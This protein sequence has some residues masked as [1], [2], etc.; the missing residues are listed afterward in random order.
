MRKIAVEKGRPSTSKVITGRSP[1]T[2]SAGS[3][4]SDH[5]GTHQWNFTG[6]TPEWTDSGEP[7]QKVTGNLPVIT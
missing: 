1:V 5:L 3:S 7:A 2:F 6:G 4:E